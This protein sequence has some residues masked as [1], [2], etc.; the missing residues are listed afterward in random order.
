ML[1]ES[2]FVLDVAEKEL[3]L[4][5]TILPSYT[6][7]LFVDW[8]C[9]VRLRD[10]LSP[11]YPTVLTMDRRNRYLGIISEIQRSIRVRG[12]KICFGQSERSLDLKVL[13]VNR[14]LKVKS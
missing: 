2:N 9:R 12:L 1:R 8:L 3:K 5:A 10:I 7:A 4:P 13:D 6:S 14:N 11:G